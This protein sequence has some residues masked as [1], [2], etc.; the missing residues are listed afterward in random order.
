MHSRIEQEETVERYVRHQLAP[1]DQ[2]AFEEHLF[3]CEE[4][5]EKLQDMERF[6]AGIRDA[7]TRGVLDHETH[8]D[9]G[10]GT[11][12]LWA[13]A[14]TTCTTVAFVA[15]A[16]W[17]YFGQ[18]PTL[19]RELDRNVAQLTLERQ[20]RAEPAPTVPADGGEANVALV[21]LQ[22]SRAGEKPASAILSA[23]SRHL[24]LWVEIGPSRYRSFR[25]DLMAPGNRPIA[26]LDRLE[27]GPYGAL[28]ASLPVEKLPAGDVRITLTGQ[29]PPPVSVVGDYQLRIQR[30]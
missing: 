30:R 20:A 19:R 2:H 24:V 3:G 11:W 21:I 16:A 4:C 27:R 13:F 9:A 12:L 23:G 29:D 7:A 5:F 15:I 26:S 1:E 17:M 10:R 6:R 14:A 8:A 22:A 25:L 18:I 28:V